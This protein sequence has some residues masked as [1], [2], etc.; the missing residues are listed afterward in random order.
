MK[1]TWI[2]GAQRAICLEARY[3]RRPRRGNLLNGW[4][5]DKLN[6]EWRRHTL[7]EEE[8]LLAEIGLIGSFWNLR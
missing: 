2:V 1:S 3:S 8:A 6:P 7:E 4:F 5:K